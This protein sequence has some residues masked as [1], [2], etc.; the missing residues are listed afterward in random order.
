M[1]R[2]C[3]GDR[4]ILYS[5]VSST[6]WVANSHLKPSIHMVNIEKLWQW[7]CA[8]CMLNF[9]SQLKLFHIPVCHYSMIYCVFIPN[10]DAH[11][12][13]VFSCLICCNQY[14][15]SLLIITKNIMFISIYNRTRI[16]QAEWLPQ[17]LHQSSLLKTCRDRETVKGLF[18]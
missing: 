7:N 10:P 18:Y 3:P 2:R 4:H 13:Q 6:S 12:F 11:V 16:R 5:V 9:L 17:D 8:E 15:R 14:A 1:D